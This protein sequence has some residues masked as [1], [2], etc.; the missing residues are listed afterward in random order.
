MKTIISPRAIVLAALTH[1]P[2]TPYDLI[3]RVRQ[4]SR[5]KLKLHAGVVYPTLLRLTKSKLVS[6]DKVKPAK[7]RVMQSY[8]LTSKG[9]EE[10][11]GIQKVVNLLYEGEFEPRELKKPGPKARGKKD[12]KAKR[13]AKSKSSKA[14]LVKKA[15]KAARKGKRVKLAKAPKAKTAKNGLPKLPPPAAKAN[16]KTEAQPPA[17]KTTPRGVPT[18]LGGPPAT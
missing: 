5:D 17:A 9:K 7:K 6:I 2:S 3:D 11:H 1:G 12:G 14:R 13:V 15:S 10:A 8:S 16:D 18:M 4:L